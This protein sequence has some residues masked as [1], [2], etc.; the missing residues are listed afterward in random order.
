MDTF[1]HIFLDIEAFCAF[2]EVTLLSWVGL[3]SRPYLALRRHAS[4][5]AISRD[6]R[7]REQTEIWSV[8]N[9]GPERHHGPRS[10]LTAE[11]TQ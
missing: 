6:T 11:P 7:G 4:F 9:L 10:S 8:L 1:C 3:G 2:T 5:E